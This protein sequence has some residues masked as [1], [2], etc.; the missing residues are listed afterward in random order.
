MELFNQPF[1]GAMGDKLKSILNSDIYDE[2]TIFVAF[3]KESA[4]L[5]IKKDLDY[6]RRNGRGKITAYVGIDLEGTS[7]EA[8]S[9]LLTSVD[10]LNIVHATTSQTF[11]PKIYDFTN[12]QAGL[13]IV[14]SHNLTLGGLWGNFE[15]SIIAD[16]N[17]SQPDGRKL[18]Q[19]VSDYINDLK[20]L[21]ASFQVV[22]DQQFI[23]DLL[24]AGEISKEALIHAKSRSTQKTSSQSKAAPSIF[25]KGKS[26]ALPSSPSKSVQ[27]PHTT[28]NNLKVNSGAIIPPT[29][30]VPSGLSVLSSNLNDPILWYS[31]KALTGG[32][33]N[34]IDLSKE[35]LVSKGNP[36]GTPF[37]GS[38]PHLM[39]G[40]VEFFGVQPNLTGIVTKITI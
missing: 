28:N 25:G 7:Y 38:K 17:L 19:S 32:S 33:S 20:S 30:Q 34:Q 5:R 24:K 11:H 36:N 3:A 15:S 16:T 13:T 26:V 40:A 39:R 6:F 31:T 22:P 18:R 2:L 14:G 23:D 21:G 10:S 8:L 1:S 37:A 35:S 4:V 29:P 12:R 27:H 9:S